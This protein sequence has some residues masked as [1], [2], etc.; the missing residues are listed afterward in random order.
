MFKVHTNR[1]SEETMK[2]AALFFK[3]VAIV[4]VG[5]AL[6]L[7]MVVI[8]AIAAAISPFTRK[9]HVHG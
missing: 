9:T 5:V 1:K 8:G 7:I 6:W 3:S 4:A 2:K